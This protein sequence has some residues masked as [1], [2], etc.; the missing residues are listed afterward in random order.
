MLKSKHKKNNA[1]WQRYE[2]ETEID[3]LCSF[4]FQLAVIP[5]SPE[6]SAKSKIFFSP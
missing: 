4:A 2:V 5:P 1:G 6:N 3:L